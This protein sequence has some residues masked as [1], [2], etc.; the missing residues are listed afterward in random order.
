VTRAPISVAPVPR[1]PPEGHVG[2]SNKPGC[3]GWC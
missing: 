3:G 2:E 1:R